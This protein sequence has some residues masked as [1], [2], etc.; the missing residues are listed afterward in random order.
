MVCKMITHH[1]AWQACILGSLGSPAAETGG[2][3]GHSLCYVSSRLA[4]IQSAHI[5]PWAE[6]LIS[7]IKN[8]TKQNIW[9]GAQY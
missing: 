5:R 9:N 6:V 8:K 7:S 2:G 3:K 4:N 1:P